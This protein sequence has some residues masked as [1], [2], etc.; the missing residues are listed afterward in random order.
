MAAFNRALLLTSP[1]FIIGIDTGGT[2]TDAVVIAR[3][4][5]KV[6]ASAKALTTKGDLSIGVGE[7]MARALAAVSGTV[8]AKAISLVSISTTLAT[9]AVVEGHGSAAAAIL[10][11][12][13]AQMVER[14]GIAAAFPDMPIVQV[15]GG[16]DHNGEAKTKLDIAALG[17]AVS[18]LSGKVKSFA[19]ASAFAVRNSAHEVKARELVDQLTKAPATLSS[20]LSSSLDAP[21]RALTAVLNARLIS[22]ITHLIAAVKTAMERLQLSCP[23]MIMKGD[24]SLA[25]A[26]S[27]AL[28]PIETILSGPAASLVGAKWLSGLDDFI[29]SDMGGTT[30]DVGLVLNGQPQ[31]ASQGAEVGGWRTMVK[32]IDVKTIGLGGDSEVS[33]VANG[34]LEI[35]P[36]RAVP[37]SLLASRHPQVIAMLEADLSET[38]G[39]SMHGKFVCL[40][41]GRMVVTA[42]DGLKPREA[43]LLAMVGEMPVPFRKIAVSSAAQ[44]ALQVLRRK[45][46]LQVCTFTPSDAAHVLN[47]QSNWNREAAVLGAQLLHRFRT[48]K[49]AD[50]AGLMAIAR[51]VWDETVF[52]SAHV[53]LHTA[54]GDIKGC[55][56]LVD[57]VARGQAV[58]GQAK[59]AISPHVP[60]VA[61]GGPVRIYYTEV[62]RRLGCDVVFA[63][64]CDVANA[65]G[66]AAALVAVRVVVNVEG[67][68]NGSFRVH[69]EGK[70]LL[71]GSGKLALA[72]A[73]KLARAGAEKRAMAGGSSHPRV[74]L[75]EQ[76]SL[77]PESRDEDGLLTAIITAEATGRPE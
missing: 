49:M 51:E 61:V 9:N 17:D 2:Y 19:V 44:R 72:E 55:E 46:L 24:G 76:L 38:D 52:K 48:M 6:L 32:A 43:E 8:E 10:I 33:V 34:R 22:H 75:T 7:A 54:L 13:D 66:A 45:G 27:V 11:G 15:A 20:E 59:I 60:L 36:Q 63:P 65:V 58:M 30:T 12:F 26:D 31:I 37:L 71:F 64:F 77:L 3:D 42:A 56:T 39:A 25:L 47:L 35:G 18:A 16:H 29:L 41:F 50:E 5:H 21:R 67:D 62:A 28:R 57:A 68:G 69:G 1:S 14:T 40:P 73:R 4:S 74:E 70:S 23:L 53:M